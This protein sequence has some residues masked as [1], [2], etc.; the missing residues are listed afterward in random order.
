MGADCDSDSELDAYDADGMFPD[1][2]DE[3]TLSISKSAKRRQRRK[4]SGQRVEN[5][6]SAVWAWDTSPQNARPSDHGAKI[7]IISANPCQPSVVT[8]SDLGLDIFMQ[9]RVPPL[10]QRPASVLEPACHAGFQ[11]Q[12][13]WAPSMSQAETFIAS[14]NWIPVPMPICFGEHVPSLPSAP[15]PHTMFSVPGFRSNEP[16]ATAPPMTPVHGANCLAAPR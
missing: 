15:S 5:V 8:V 3:S 14:E 11:V 6:V 1:L 4:R 7:D 10:L 12:Q 2:G 16:Q 13:Q 9:S